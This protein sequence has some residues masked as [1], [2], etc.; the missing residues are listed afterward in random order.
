MTDFDSPADRRR[1]PRAIV[2]CEASV[3]L[4]NARR[5]EGSTVDVSS[6]GVCLSL[7]VALQPGERCDL[8]LNIGTPD[9]V[10]IVE[11]QGRVCFCLPQKSGYRIGLHCTHIDPD[12][13]LLI[14]D[15]LSGRVN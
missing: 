2:R 13:A 4:D 14:S 7:P 15:L 3:A 6:A 10:E 11:M 1:A 8:R 5:V 9:R 12:D